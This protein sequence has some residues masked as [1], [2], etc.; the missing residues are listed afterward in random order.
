M[1]CKHFHKQFFLI[2]F[3]GNFKDQPLYAKA[4]VILFLL[5]VITYTA[6]TALD[7]YLVVQ[8]GG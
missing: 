5:F 8:N 2:L 3:S 6:Y 4:V 1:T 7:I